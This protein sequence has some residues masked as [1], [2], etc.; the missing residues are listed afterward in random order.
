MS[1]DSALVYRHDVKE[2][3]DLNDKQYVARC[4]HLYALAI[5][6]K[7]RLGVEYAFHL[8]MICATFAVFRCDWKSSHWIILWL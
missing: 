1:S 7:A 2:D 3:I 6:P 4:L 8:N 5:E